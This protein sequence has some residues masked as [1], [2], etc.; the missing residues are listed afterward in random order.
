MQTM[1][2]EQLQDFA[3]SGD[4]PEAIAQALGVPFVRPAAIPEGF[5]PI[6]R[7]FTLNSSGHIPDKELGTV[8]EAC[9]ERMEFFVSRIRKGD[10][11]SGLVISQTSSQRGPCIFLTVSNYSHEAMSGRILITLKGTTF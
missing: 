6:E 5:T 3:L 10:P 2:L 1:S 9:M 7:Q 11:L 8:I 4:I